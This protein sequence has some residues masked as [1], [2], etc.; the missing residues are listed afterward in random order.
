MTQRLVSV[1][2]DFVLPA[3]VLADLSTRFAAYGVGGVSAQ[4]VAAASA[5]ARF[6]SAGQTK[7]A[8]INEATRDRVKAATSSIW[9]WANLTGLAGSNSVGVSG[10]R[11]Y[12]T[13]NTSP[14]GAKIPVT[15]GPEGLMF[16]TAI[17]LGTAGSFCGVGFAGTDT[18]MLASSTDAFM[19]GANTAKQ[20]TYHRGT[21]V[22]GTGQS[23]IDSSVTWL[24]GD[25]LIVTGLI[26]DGEVSLA[27]THPASKTTFTRTAA[28]PILTSAFP[29][30]SVGHIILYTGGLSGGASHQVWPVSIMNAA[31]ANRASAVDLV[32][33]AQP[34]HVH[35][36]AGDGDNR[37][38]IIAPGNDPKVPAPLAVYLHNSG[39]SS[40]NSVQDSRITG[41]VDALLAAGINVVMADASGSAW[42]N[43]V[44]RG[45][46]IAAFNWAKSLVSTSNVFLVGQSMGGQVAWNLLVRR[47]IPGVTA[48]LLVAAVCALDSLYANGSYVG[49]IKTAF[50]VA[51]DGSDYATKAGPYRPEGRE[52]YEFRGVPVMLVHSA[53]DTVCPIADANAIV[54]KIAPYS[55]QAVVV[56][57]TGS[58][59]A[60]PQFATAITSGIPFLQSY[61]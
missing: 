27:I 32:P 25:L 47:E 17:T 20:P 19:I 40:V 18:A 35:T 57:S 23:I 42:G 45:Q 1:G 26:R 53:G 50:G 41:F 34:Q 52:G 54:A 59:M 5:V 58:H 61:M 21:G 33:S 22:G 7:Q 11:L 3:P 48:V 29:G 10:N 43:D 30:G 13:V 9:T 12:T 16:V 6:D 60:A 4:A 2:D 56:P 39:G 28:T 15:V 55:P 46:Y 8:A 38:L 37:H 24:A 31:V 14:Q 49:N 51:S 36:V 44:S